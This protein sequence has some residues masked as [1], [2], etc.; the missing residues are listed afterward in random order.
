MGVAA[1]QG[2]SVRWLVPFMALITCTLTWLKFHDPR[3]QGDQA[4]WRG[5]GVSD[6]QRIQE[7]EALKEQQFQESIQDI[8]NATLG[9]HSL[10]H[11]HRFF[12][13]TNKCIVQ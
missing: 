3:L 6:Q 5:Q 9:V 7:E 1:Y 11:F 2:R 13:F 8:M 4:S 12:S 10:R